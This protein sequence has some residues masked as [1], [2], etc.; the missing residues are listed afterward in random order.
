MRAE[1][2]N[3]AKSEFLANM[4]HEIRTPMNAIIG[5]T[6]LALDTKLTPGQR[7]SLGMVKE[8]SNSLLTVIN[9]I[10]DFSKIESG[11]FELE[12]I[13]FGLWR[14]LGDTV[15]TLAHR[16]EEGGLELTY[17]HPPE[18][19]ET[20]EGDPTRLRQVLINLIGNAI[21]FTKQGEVSVHVE[22]QSRAQDE[23]TL[24]FWVTDTG[25]GIPREKQQLIFEAFAQADSSMTRRYGG[26]GLGLAISSQLVRMMGGEIWVESEPGRGSTFHFTARLGLPAAPGI[27]PASTKHIILRGLRVLV[28]DDNP[29]NRRILEDTLRNWEMIP[30]LADSGDAALAALQEAKQAGPP[31]AVVL[32]DAQMPGMDGFTLVEKIRQDPEMVGVVIM[33][34]TSAGRRGDASRCRKAG[35]AAYLTKPIGRSDL[36]E[37]LLRTLGD[38]GEKGRPRSLVTRHSIRESCRPLRILLTEDNA[39]NLALGT[40]L[41]EKRGH[42]VVAARNGEEAVALLESASPA[43][44]DLVLMDVQMPEMDGFQATAAIREKEKATGNHIPIIAMTAHA[45]KGDRERCLNGGM[46]GYIAKPIEPDELFRV[47]ES[48]APAKTSE[49][50]PTPSGVQ[51]GGGLDTPALLARFDGD[52]R[53]LGELAQIFIQEAP[54]MLGDIRQ[55]VEKQDAKALEKAAHALKGSVGYFGLK[56]VVETALK[57]ERIGRSEELEGAAAALRRLEEE[58][59]RLTPELAKLQAGEIPCKS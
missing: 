1:A 5:M 23:V 32:T 17:H 33:M 40:R 8:S 38:E 19:V 47:V 35:V 30:V 28:V 37:A 25:I 48:L 12:N 57:L 27:K 20:V 34:L 41:L 43:E 2:A 16:A 13:E 42:K 21:K 39:V 52:A 9:D 18:L 56:E 54:R 46:D 4:S 58:L 50:K 55:A 29:T 44:F 22:E 11:R 15:K 26:T 45:L 7:E 49:A 51:L 31:F 3:R 24:H 6:E 59:G 36:L 14:N 53:L 10:L